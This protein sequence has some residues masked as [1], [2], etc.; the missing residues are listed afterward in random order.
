LIKNETLKFVCELNFKESG[1]FTSSQNEV[2]GVLRDP[3]G[4]KLRNIIGR[5]DHSL[6]YFTDDAPDSLNVIWR[7]KSFPQNFRDNYGFTQFA[8]ELNEQTDDLKGLL[9][10]T[11][12]RLRPD[13]W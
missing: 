3:Q 10:I 13:Q 9:P 1:Y 8:I 5:W 6:S 12:T 11:D 2:S 4:K 7:A